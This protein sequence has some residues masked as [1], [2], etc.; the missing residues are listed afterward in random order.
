MGLPADKAVRYSARIFPSMLNGEPEY[1]TSTSP[2]QRSLES[3][4][5]LVVDDDSSIRQMVADYLG[6]NDMKVT[7]LA[8]GN[9]I[10]RVTGQQTIDL[11]I[12]D[13]K[14]PG[15]DGFDVLERLQESAATKLL[16]VIVLTAK[17]L[18]TDE[19]E[20]LRERAVSLL[21]KSAY[22]PQELKRL[23]DRALAQ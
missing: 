16:P 18:T 3:T 21:E 9:D 13:L 11:L 7:A 12:L 15:L 10:A 19:R 8:S 1:V 20:E 6:D 22:S 23:V 5:I 17:R 2:D 4:H 14:M